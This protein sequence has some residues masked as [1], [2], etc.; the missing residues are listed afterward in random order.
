[1]AGMELTVVEQID[2]DALGMAGNERRVEGGWGND[3]N[4]RHGYERLGQDK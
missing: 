4:G 2:G 1:M 3:Q